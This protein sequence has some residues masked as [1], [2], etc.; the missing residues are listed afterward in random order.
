ME[1]T[2]TNP[3]IESTPAAVT[4]AASPWRLMWWRF[5]RHR[6]AVISMVIVAIFYVVAA[7]CE[8]F[9]PYDPN[10]YYA[11]YQLTP[12]QQLRFVDVEG[13]FSL[14][15]FVYERTRTLNP[16]TL[17][18]IYS[19]NPAVKYPVYFFV[20]NGIEYEM[21]GEWEMDFHLI[22]VQDPNAKLFLLGADRLGRDV[23]S[24]LIYG[25]RPSMTIGLVGV[26]LSL[27]LGIFLGGISGYFGGWIDMGI[28]RLIEMISALPTIPLWMGLAAAVPLD[29]GPL[30][31]YFMI[32]II[33]SLIGWTGLARVVRGRFLSLR[34][35]DFIKAARMAGSSEYRIIFRHMLPSMLS[36]IIASVTLA[37]PGMILAET[38]LSF[39]GLGLKPPVV[40]WGVLLQEAQNLRTVALAPWNLAPAIP[41]VVAI[42][43]LNFLGDGLRD[44][45]D[46][47]GKM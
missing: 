45:A 32:T 30:Q 18:W 20:N 13:N 11:E 39:L 23:L 21:W 43:T 29:W 27:V 9:A 8:F 15:P 41:V 17:A 3:A 47:Y 36:H 38:S 1:A 34:S 31:T 37:I 35:E 16:E 22:G 24:R 2:L 33:L 10:T 7:F 12:P 6:L 28:Q 19:D 4:D 25:T 26:A 40:S 44:A 5:T 46:P 42:L 14:R